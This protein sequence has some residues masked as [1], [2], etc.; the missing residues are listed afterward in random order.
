VSRFEKQPA[1]AS[2]H[3]WA[4][5]LN[6]IDTAGF[7][8][9]EYEELKHWRTIA[10]NAALAEDG[11]RHL[12]RLEQRRREEA[13][14]GPVES[15]ALRDCKA[16]ALALKAAASALIAEDRQAYTAWVQRGMTD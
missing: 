3:A 2:N 7:G 15:P 9:G 11:Q 10:R 14:H 5:R 13:A 4:F 1:D 6:T 16:A 8:H 12:Q